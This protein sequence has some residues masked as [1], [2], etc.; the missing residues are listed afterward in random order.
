MLTFV[1]C[2]DKCGYAEAIEKPESC[3]EFDGEV[4]PHGKLAAVDAVLMKQRFYQ[5]SRLV[6]SKAGQGIRTRHFP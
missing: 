5:G 6:C 2:H 1:R 3:S 4:M